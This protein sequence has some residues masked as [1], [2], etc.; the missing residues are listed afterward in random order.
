MMNTKFNGDPLILSLREQYPKQGPDPEP[1]EPIEHWAERFM[2][3]KKKKYD[4][5]EK[6][7]R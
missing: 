7:E 6:N 4:L 5:E 3:K 2:E 1:G